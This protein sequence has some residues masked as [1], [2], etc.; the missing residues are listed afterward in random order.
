MKK[1]A[2]CLLFWGASM[3][4]SADEMARLD[5]AI[6]AQRAEVISALSGGKLSVFRRAP[7]LHRAEMTLAANDVK[8]ADQAC[9]LAFKL[10]GEPDGVSS[11]ELLL[12]AEGVKISQYGKPSPVNV[13]YFGRVHTGPYVEL[14]VSFEM[15]T[16]ESAARVVEAFQALTGTCRDRAVAI[17]KAEAK[18]GMFKAFSSMQQSSD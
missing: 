14:G 2:A 10:S 16:A 8:N 11:A 4:A 15:P 5:Q 7:S 1:L 17:K 9:S 18:M 13:E 12:A 3:G 6:S